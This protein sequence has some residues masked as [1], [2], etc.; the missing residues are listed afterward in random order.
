MYLTWED[1]SCKVSRRHLWGHDV[2]VGVEYI[3]F[4]DHDLL[5]TE[6]QSDNRGL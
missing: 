2:L 4:L 6:Q 5:S 1:I 3:V